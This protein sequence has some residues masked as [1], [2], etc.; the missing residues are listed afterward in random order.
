MDKKIS[1][2][3]RPIHGYYTLKIFTRQKEGM[4]K[5]LN[6]LKFGEI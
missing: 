4:H 3:S 5:E 2:H 6:N 1:E